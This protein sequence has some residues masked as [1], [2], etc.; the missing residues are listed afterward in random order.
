MRQIFGHDFGCINP[1]RNEKFK[2]M[3]KK[4]FFSFF[5]KIFF[6]LFLIF[7][8]FTVCKSNKI[9]KT[10]P[11]LKNSKHK[12]VKKLKKLKKTLKKFLQKNWK[13]TLIFEIFHFWL[14]LYPQNHDQQFV[15]CLN[16]MIIYKKSMWHACP[17]H[18][19]AY[20]STTL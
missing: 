3:Q 1:I 12:T 16:F 2:K 15:S 13:K 10:S 11:F 8:Q 18:T 9:F 19:K 17:L 5:L 4:I 20:K 6:S 14:E 7:G